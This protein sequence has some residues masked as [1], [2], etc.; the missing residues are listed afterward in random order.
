MLTI[1]QI[2]T[3]LFIKYETER[4]EAEKEILTIENN[5]MAGIIKLQQFLIA[6]TAILSLAI[7]AIIFFYLRYRNKQQKR[8][9]EK[10]KIAAELKALKAQ[11]KPHFIQNIFQ[12]I[13]NQVSVN[14]SEVAVFLQKT[15]N[16]FRSVLNGTDKN[17][18]SLEDELTFTEKYIQFQ[19]SLFQDKLTYKI[20]IT[21]DVDTYGIMV[22]TMLLQP[23]IE[24]SI[25]YGL[26][27]TQLPTHIDVVCHKD[28][29]YFYY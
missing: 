13:A 25:K 20:N 7:I 27:I 23:F 19:Q 10:E 24:N 21:D 17:V 5:K 9:A 22:P 26:Q 1:L 6:S 29:K 18:Q 14:P 3:N 28:D 15:A 4:K 8:L 11:L 12:I 2:L 16:Y